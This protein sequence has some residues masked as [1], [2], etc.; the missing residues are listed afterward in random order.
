MSEEFT[1]EVDVCSEQKNQV[2][3]HVHWGGMKTK[4]LHT[5]FGGRLGSLAVLVVEICGAYLIK[6]RKKKKSNIILPGF[7][8]EPFG[9]SKSK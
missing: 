1:A 7:N 3:P 6:K 4:L 2:H 5:V 8:F 9:L